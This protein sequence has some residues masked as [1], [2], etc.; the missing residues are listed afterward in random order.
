[1]SFEAVFDGYKRTEEHI[2]K[3]NIMTAY[4][5]IADMKQKVKD[6]FI[7]WLEIYK[8][9]ARGYSQELLTR[10]KIPTIRLLSTYGIVLEQKFSEIFDARIFD[11]IYILLN[12][13]FNMHNCPSFFVVA[14]AN[15][16]KNTSIFTEVQKALT[17][18]SLPA[19]TKFPSKLDVLLEEI[20]RS[21]A[22]IINY[23]RGQYDNT[24]S[25]PL[26]LHEAV[27]CIYSLTG[28]QNFEEKYSD[29]SWCREAL[30]DIYITNF[31][32]PSYAT[33]LANYLRRFPYLEAA[34]HLDFCARLYISLLYLTELTKDEDFSMQSIKN[35][36]NDAF[37][38]VKNIWE[39]HKQN[40]PHE[41]QDKA[42][43]IYSAT[44]HQ[45]KKSMLNKGVKPFQEHL[46][47]VENE[48]KNFKGINPIAQAFSIEDVLSYYNLGIPISAD[49]RI[50]FNA[51]ISK[52]FQESITLATNIFITQ[53]LKKWHIC[54]IWLKAEK[55]IS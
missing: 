31:F 54:K 47:N 33:A 12:E 38:Y 40:A 14:E 24:L 21:D 28:L 37:N 34:S 44:A 25:W 43:D 10:S 49:P 16:F 5:F 55:E 23:E 6:L 15:S 1:L 51:F 17:G 20:R 3:Q 22:F 36:I 7:K 42:E 18:L 27:H 41:V 2:K 32:G 13:F 29:V 19:A 52:K 30:I 46:I 45:I 4:I 11:E 9:Y 50:L 26:L 39:Q 53:S 48:R 35:Q 8:E